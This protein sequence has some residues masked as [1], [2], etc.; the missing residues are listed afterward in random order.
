MDAQHP[1]AD[2]LAQIGPTDNGGILV[3]G[4][5]GPD[6][7]PRASAVVAIRK[8]DSFTFG[9]EFTWEKGVKPSATAEVVWRF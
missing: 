1:F 5:I 7:S 2:A 9:A 8:G 3:R 4:T 6:G